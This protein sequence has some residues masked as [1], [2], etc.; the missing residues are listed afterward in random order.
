MG[1]L[2]V[3]IAALAAVHHFAHEIP[4]RGAAFA[5]PALAALA[6]V[7]PAQSRCASAALADQDRRATEQW[8]MSQASMLDAM[9]A[10]S[11][12]AP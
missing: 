3:F 7:S 12:C 11:R 4:A 9:S 6:P 5:G 2:L 10:A 8:S 1:K